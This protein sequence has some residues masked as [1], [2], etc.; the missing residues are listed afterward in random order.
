MNVRFPFSFALSP[1]LI[2]SSILSIGL[3]EDIAQAQTTNEFA[4]Q[5][6]TQ[7]DIVTTSPPLTN[8]QPI[9]THIDDVGLNAGESRTWDLPVEANIEY[10]IAAVCDHDCQN[11]DLELLEDGQTVDSDFEEDAYPMIVGVTGQRSYQARITMQT[12]AVS[13]CYSGFRLFQ[14]DE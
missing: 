11:I 3:S 5:I 2:V 9:L 10:V 7:L 13:P 1:L 4:Q 14:R 6:R 8:Y 12:C